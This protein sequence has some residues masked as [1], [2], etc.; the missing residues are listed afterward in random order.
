MKAAYINPFINAV[1]R[2]FKTMMA[3]PI[4]VGPPGLNRRAQPQHD[5]CGVI[6]VSGT[7]KGRV[8]VSM[9]ENLAAALAS[10]LIGD[11]IE[12]LDEDCIDAVGEIANMIAGNAKTD[13]PEVGS[14]IS[15][16]WVVIG[17][18]GVSYPPATPVINI[19]CETDKGPLQIDVALKTDV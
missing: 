12:A 4:E 15:V 1:S 9:P 19:P 7:V 3:F 17:R 6:D 11:T 16:P 8:V 14:A 10:I 18:E 13:F 5:V 2:L